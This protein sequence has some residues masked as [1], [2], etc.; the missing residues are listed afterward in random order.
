MLTLRTDKKNK[1]RNSIK[2]TSTDIERA[3]ILIIIYRNSFTNY[4]FVCF[5][6]K[7]WRH[8]SF[9]EETLPVQLCGSDGAGKRKGTRATFLQHRSGQI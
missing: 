2:I 4:S 9:P 8:F 1:S 5:L 3:F 6:S 7:L